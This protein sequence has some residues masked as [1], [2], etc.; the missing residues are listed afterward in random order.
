MKKVLDNTDYLYIKDMIYNIQNTLLEYIDSDK[1]WDTIKVTEALNKLSD[2]S[3][4]INR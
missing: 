4:I 1:E 3:S 2:F